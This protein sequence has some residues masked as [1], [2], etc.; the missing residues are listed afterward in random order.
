MNFPVPTGKGEAKWKISH[1]SHLK[2]S[3]SVQAQ[4]PTALCAMG[5]TVGPHLEQNAL[6]VCWQGKTSPML[7]AAVGRGVF[8][9]APCCEGGLT[10]CTLLLEG[11]Y[12]M[13]PAAAGGGFFPMH[14]G[15]EGAL[16]CALLLLGGVSFPMHP[17]TGGA[18]LC[19]PC[20]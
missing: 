1:T 16:P 15:A 8:P 3:V 4:L 12:P 10:L 18:L 20:C 11:P 6:H 7:P 14:P 9:H 5:P 19:V 2:T 17:A 13:H